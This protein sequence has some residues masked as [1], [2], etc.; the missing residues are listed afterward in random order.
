M[1]DDASTRNSPA[2]D[3]LNKLAAE[4]REANPELSKSQAFAKVFS[5]P[6]NRDLAAAERRENRP[7]AL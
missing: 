4:L 1:E 2:L 5:D 7:T 3:R 6:A